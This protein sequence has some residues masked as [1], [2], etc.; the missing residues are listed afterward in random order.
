[1]SNIGFV[2]FALSLCGVVVVQTANGTGTNA[3][4]HHLK[5]EDWFH[6][7]FAIG[8][9]EF[10]FKD[11]LKFNGTIQKL[12]CLGSLVGGGGGEG[13]NSKDNLR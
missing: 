3:Q 8:K 4:E 5:E 7:Q 12:C 13:S 6:N 1:M 9:I 2:L 11:L 10:P